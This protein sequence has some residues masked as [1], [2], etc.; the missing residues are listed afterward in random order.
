M[1]IK[2]VTKPGIDKI[3]CWLLIWDL[4][5]ANLLSHY[6]DLKHLD[7][8]QVQLNMKSPYCP[9]WF[10]KKAEV[11]LENPKR[12]I[13]FLL[14]FDGL[15]GGSVFHSKTEQLFIQIFIIVKFNLQNKSV[16]MSHLLNVFFCPECLLITK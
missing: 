13:L 10:S 1:I 7:F 8:M 5:G 3:E 14:L 15:R 16:E 2:N 12:E 11:W 6:S 9:I 4:V